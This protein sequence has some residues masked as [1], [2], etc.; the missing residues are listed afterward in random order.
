[1]KHLYKFVFGDCY[2]GSV[3]GLFIADEKEV[4]DTIGKELYF[5]EILGKH[6][7]V[8]GTFDK[9]DFEIIDLPQETLDL[10]EKQFKN[11]VLSGYNP[12]DYLPEDEDDD[13][14]E[15]DKEDDEEED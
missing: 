6:S 4:N 8:Y 3:E 15:D 2:Y 10:L 11:N 14:E 1:M 5:G 12:L 7:A 13:D 9:T